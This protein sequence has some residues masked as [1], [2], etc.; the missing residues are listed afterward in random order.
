MA[1]KKN[2][3]TSSSSA[4]TTTPRPIGISMNIVQAVATID[5]HGYTKSE[6]IRRLTEFL[7]RVTSN[8]KSRRNESTNTSCCW[9]EVVTGSGSHSQHGRK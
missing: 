6:A 4:V 3:R 8:N 9:V 1:K 5:L 7:D 2:R